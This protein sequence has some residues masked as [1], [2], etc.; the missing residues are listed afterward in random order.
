MCN[1]LSEVTRLEAEV[2]ELRAA[3]EAV[4]DFLDGAHSLNHHGAALREVVNAALAKKGT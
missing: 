4:A 2:V 3:L 1:F